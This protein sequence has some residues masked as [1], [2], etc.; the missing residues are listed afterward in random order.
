MVNKLK[1]QILWAS[2][3]NQTKFIQEEPLLPSQGEACNGGGWG[4]GYKF[5]YSSKTGCKNECGSE[6]LGVAPK[7]TLV[8]GRDPFP[9]RFPLVSESLPPMA[10]WQETEREKNVKCPVLKEG[11]ESSW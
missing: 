8:K 5:S 7:Q 4:G 9:R 10:T 6:I 11:P 1:Q 3:E 2:K